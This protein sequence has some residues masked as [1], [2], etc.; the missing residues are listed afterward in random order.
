M[1]CDFRLLI[2]RSPQILFVLSTDKTFVNIG[3]KLTGE[4]RTPNQVVFTVFGSLIVF[5]QLLL[6]ITVEFRVMDDR[7]QSYPP[8]HFDIGTWLQTKYYFRQDT[9]VSNSKATLDLTMLVVYVH[10][11]WFSTRYDLLTSL[12][13]DFN[14]P[15]GSIW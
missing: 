9:L 6:K 1:N 12:F 10:L 2:S 5:N 7:C 8:N 3:S 14:K 13:S 11:L 15:F 4:V